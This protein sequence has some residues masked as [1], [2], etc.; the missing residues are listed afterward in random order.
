MGGAHIL[1]FSRFSS[2]NFPSKAQCFR[3]RVRFV[4]VGE[5]ALASWPFFISPG[6]NRFLLPLSFVDFCSLKYLYAFD[7]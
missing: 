2:R 7:E 3:P 4:T 1:A 5:R 6:Q